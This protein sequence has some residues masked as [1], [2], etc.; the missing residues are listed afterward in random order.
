MSSTAI[1]MVI[2]PRDRPVGAAVVQRVLPY[3]KRRMVGPFI[4]ADIFGP[5]DYAP[6]TGSDVDAHPHLGLSTL[7]YLFAGELLHRDSTGAVSDIRPGDVNWM[8]AGSGVCHT[9]RTPA[10]VR[11]HE[12]SLAGLQT[13]VALPVSDEQRAPFFEHADA[14]DIPR[15]TA[16]GVSITVAAGHGWSLESPV[17]GSSPLL[18]AEIVLAD[19]A[20]T[21]PAEHR[22]RAVIAISGSLRVAGRRLEPA[23]AAVLTPGE[24]VELHGTGRAM[25]LAG[26]PVG[27]RY[28]WWNFVASDRDLIDQ[29]KRDWDAQRFP[30]IPGD[31]DVWVPA[32][33]L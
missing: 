19:T 8:T 24:P 27:D 12:H 18:E 25:L 21:I 22:E 13:W 28:I 14:A 23:H 2:E 17:R 1:E 4:F 9:E 29:A 16:P 6:G 33:P 31:H 10:E 30:L 32:P 5:D 26:D 3:R 15:D 11:S 20:V 7:S